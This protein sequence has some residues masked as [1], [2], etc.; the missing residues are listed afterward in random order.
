MAQSAGSQARAQFTLQVPN[1]P[2]WV[3]LP[4]ALQGAYL[5]TSAPGF[6]LELSNA[7]KAQFAL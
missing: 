1:Q 2:L 6:P 3:G 5:A 7:L 4:I